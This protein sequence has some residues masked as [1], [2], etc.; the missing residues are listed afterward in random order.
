MKNRTIGA[1][2]LCAA[3]FAVNEAR[4]KTWEIPA[5]D[6]VGD[7]VALTNALKQV[8]HNDSIVLAPGVYY[9]SNT[10]MRSGY[11]LEFKV[12]PSSLSAT[13]LVYDFYGSDPDPSK[14]IL[15]GGQ[16]KAMVYFGLSTVTI[17]NL[18]FS[19]GYT[20]GNGGCFNYD[21]TN[22]ARGGLKC[23]NCV[24]TN[25]YAGVNGAVFYNFSSPQ[26]N[27]KFYNN[28]AAGSG[29]CGFGGTFIDCTFV[30][31]KAKQGGGLHGATAKG[32]TFTENTATASGGGTYNCTATKCIFVK[33]K[34]SGTGGG[35]YSTGTDL[36]TNCYFNAN[37]ASSQGACAYN[38]VIRDSEI[39]NHSAG[40]EVLKNTKVYMSVVSNN[41]NSGNAQT[42][43]FDSA[44]QFHNCLIAFNHRTV[45]G[46]G[47][48]TT[49]TLR[50]CTVYGNDQKA[51]ADGKSRSPCTGKAWN[52][53]FARNYPYDIIS[54]VLPSM[55][56]NCLWMTR[57]GG[58]PADAPGCKQVS[59]MRFVDET[60]GDL[61]IV[62]RSPAFNKGYQDEAYLALVGPVDRNGDPR[63]YEGDGPAKAIIDI[64]CYECQIPAPGLLMLVR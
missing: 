58:M 13:G 46:N 9:L 40:S 8:K 4:A 51:F 33:N 62:R 63:V 20:T 39:I 14:T 37:S 16:T 55:M 31:N 21:G 47:M 7:V 34:T 42:G 18:T 44:T 27:C 57:S 17:S 30:G 64:G 10:V 6:G 53:I 35:F 48:I 23:Q 59:D 54:K 41:T 61:R 36:A 28:T 45:A 12:N 26:R 38:G 22:G 49:G 52:C 56:T 5:P 32:C 43:V 60:N 15:D 19:G 11:H 50:N 1:F 25:N 3:V 24:F 29:A 2:A